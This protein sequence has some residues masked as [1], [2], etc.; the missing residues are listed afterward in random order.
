ME[1]EELLD[2]ASKTEEAKQQYEEAC[3]QERLI[4]QELDSTTILSDKLASN[5]SRRRDESCLII[6]I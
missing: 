3:S 2:I 1:S 6:T 5:T 4:K